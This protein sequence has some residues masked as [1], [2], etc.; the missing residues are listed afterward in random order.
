MCHMRGKCPLAAAGLLLAA[1]ILIPRLFAG[2]VLVR[3][4]VL[5]WG[6]HGDGYAPTF[7][8]VAGKLLAG[9]L[10]LACLVAVLK[11]RSNRVAWLLVAALAALAFVTIAMPSDR[12]L[13]M[14]ISRGNELVAQIDSFQRKAGR[15]PSRLTQVHKVPPTGLPRERRFYYASAGSSLDDAGPWFPSTRRYIGRARYVICVPLVPGG[16]LV[17]RPDGDYSDLPG[18]AQREGWFST[19]DD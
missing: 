17:Y 16:T 6:A 14:V 11:G 12:D 10:A 4:D 7:V 13:P 18:R 1:T 3:Y 2:T 15:Y 5:F 19:S 8:A 9:V